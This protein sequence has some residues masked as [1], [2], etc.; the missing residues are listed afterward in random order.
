MLLL[1]GRSKP[2][3]VAGCLGRLRYFSSEPGAEP[4][5]PGFQVNA[6]AAGRRPLL[7]AFMMAPWR[8]LT[9]PVTLRQMKRQR[10]WRRAGPQAWCH[11]GSVSDSEPSGS[12]RL[13]Q[14]EARVT[15]SRRRAT[16]GPGSGLVST[17]TWHCHRYGQSDQSRSESPSLAQLGPNQTAR[18]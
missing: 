12:L 11:S 5:F 10:P 7:I 14:L 13:S 8:P 18:V 4:G 17:G 9:L 2:H 16:R 3:S 1:P 6:A 15:V